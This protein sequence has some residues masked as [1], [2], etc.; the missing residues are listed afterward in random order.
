MD[1]VM[2]VTDDE[3]GCGMR[4]EDYSKEDTIE[5]HNVNVHLYADDTQVHAVLPQLVGYC[6]PQNTV[7][8]S[9][10]VGGTM[11]LCQGLAPP[12]GPALNTVTR[13]TVL[14]SKCT[15]NYLAAGLRPNP[16]NFF[17]ACAPHT[18]YSLSLI[19]I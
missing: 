11:A 12:T 15:S 7:A 1:G 2:V 13:G 4:Q 5:Q 14:S 17:T 19:H 16:T 10:L 6:Y 3:R 9:S 18:L 8:G